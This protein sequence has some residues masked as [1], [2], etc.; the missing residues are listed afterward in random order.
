MYIFNF[1]HVEP[2]PKNPQR[3]HIS[4]TPDG[5]AQFIR[6]IRRLGLEP[7][8]LKEVMLSGGPE[9]QPAQKVILTF[10]DGYENFYDYAAP[11]LKAEK[12]PGTVLVLAGKAGCVNDWDYPDLPE[13]KRDRLMSMAQMKALIPSAYIDIGSHG[14]NHLNYTQL[15][16]A[17]LR[18]EIWI[19]YEIL[20][21]EL[22]DGFIPVL[23]Y[24][25]GEYTQKVYD[26]MA[27]SP[28]RYG[29]TTSKGP[30]VSADRP[31]AVPRYSIYE[32]DANPLIL[33]AKLARN[34]ILKPHHAQTAV[35]DPLVASI[36]NPDIS[37][38]ALEVLN[39]NPYT[40]D[41]I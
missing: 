23:A 32:R 2:K 27:E 6:I 38:V 17:E 30:W 10:D 37:P 33:V 19:S 24:P 8:S 12:C 36:Q 9:A 35:I 22:G 18:Q 7:V 31:F 14:M 20:A 28:Y 15:T 11:I 26:I 29:L 41:A 5:L 3:K 13:E 40:R 25:W 39:R 21:K 16:D 1:H 34:G 4:I